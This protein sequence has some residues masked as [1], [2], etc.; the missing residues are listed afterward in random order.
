MQTFKFVF[1]ALLLGLF[2]VNTA[3]AQTAGMVKKT[4]VTVAP[5]VQ[6]AT[7]QVLGNCGMCKKTIEKAAAS[8]G[9]TSAI[10]DAEK[11]LLT[12]TFD[13]AK[14][15]VDAVQK[16]V[17]LS[18]YDNVGYKAPDEAYNNLHGCCQYDRSGAPGSAKSCG[19]ENEGAGH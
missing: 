15:A 19:M 1:T 7:F 4:A 2:L 18:G 9:T 14:T 10:W 5:A 3:N 16:A 8:A 17:A 6:S 12:V 11:D 13:P